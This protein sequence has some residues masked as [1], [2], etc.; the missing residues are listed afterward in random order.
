MSGSKDRSGP[1]WKDGTHWCTRQSQSWL[2]RNVDARARKVGIMKSSPPEDRRIREPGRKLGR[3]KCFYPSHGAAVPV[4][5]E[6][7]HATTA[8]GVAVHCR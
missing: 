4:L 1:G 5:T 2:K 8:C 6:M 3:R 7:P